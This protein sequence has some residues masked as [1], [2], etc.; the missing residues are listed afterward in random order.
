MTAIFFSLVA[1]RVFCA[2]V[3]S[4]MLSFCLKVDK[5]C[6]K[7]M[8]YVDAIW[9]W[10]VWVNKMMAHSGLF[11]CHCSRKW[12]IS[13]ECTYRIWA[14]LNQRGISF[15]LWVKVEIESSF[16]MYLWTLSKIMTIMWPKK[17]AEYLVAIVWCI[18]YACTCTSNVLVTKAILTGFIVH[19]IQ[20]LLLFQ[21]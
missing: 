19:G 5:F 13:R 3:S 14:E 17:V 4:V 2:A 1:D 12:L 10:K 9:W 15:L 16:V 20:R 21:L 11:L 8:F 6:N 7:C 18:P